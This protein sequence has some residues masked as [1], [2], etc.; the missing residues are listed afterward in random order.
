M[1][2]VTTGALAALFHAALSSGAVAQAP[3]VA[4][5][6]QCEYG[7]R[8]IYWQDAH[9]VYYQALFNLMPNGTFQAQGYD[10]TSG[11][12]Q[13][14]GRWS[15]QQDQGRWWFSARGQ[16]TM[17]FLGIVDFSFDSYLNTPTQMSLDLRDPAS[18]IE[19]ASM[20]QRTG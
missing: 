5:Q 18:G 12:F 8:N 2:T 6:W 17:Q 15:L 10:H 4:G 19:V 11:T 1:K 16:Q 7:S 20:C 3:S 9:A 13:A 14:Q